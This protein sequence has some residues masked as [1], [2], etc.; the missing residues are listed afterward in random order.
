MALWEEDQRI[1]LPPNFPDVQP[2][3]IDVID[4]SQLA[5]A[6]QLFQEH[7]D[8]MILEKMSGADKYLNT[9]DVYVST[10]LSDGNT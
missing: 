2:V 7:E 10:S 4:S 1:F 9:A 5:T 3:G 8:G 6:S